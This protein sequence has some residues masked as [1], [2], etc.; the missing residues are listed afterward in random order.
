MKEPNPEFSVTVP[1]SLMLMGEHAVVYGKPA[2][3]M[4]VKPEMTLTFVPA[5]DD[6]IQVHSGMG[7]LEGTRETLPETVPLRFVRQALRTCPPLHGCRI[8]IVS[9]LD[10][11]RGWGSSAAVTVGMIAGLHYLNQNPVEKQRIAEQAREVIRAVQG[12]GSGSDAAAST[13]GGIVRITPEPFRVEPLSDTPLPF[14]MAYAGY[15]TP[16]PEVIRQVTAL[17]EKHPEDID[18]AFDLMEQ[19]VGFATK[20][21]KEGNQEMLGALLNCHHEL[22]ASI[23]TSDET[24]EHLVR[25]FRGHPGVHGAK[26]SGSG[27]G[28]SVIALG[29]TSA[30]IEGFA[31]DPVTVSPKGVQIHA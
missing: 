13:F 26:I 1:G 5:T 15:K 25:C 11:T 21:L 17:R 29:T 12:S 7:T 9:D 22:Q 23:G 18:S 19:L 20:A 27:L 16:T 3:A 24:L 2:L 14:S 30:S 6:R 10:T 28:D 31:C 4:A 8:T